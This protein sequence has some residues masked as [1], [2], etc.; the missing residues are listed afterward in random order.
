M[1][2]LTREDSE[3]VVGNKERVKIAAEK[4]AQFILRLHCDQNLTDSSINGVRT[5]YPPQNATNISEDSK[6]AAQIIHTEVINA[7]KLTNGG[8]H[9]DTVASIDPVVGMLVGSEEADKYKIPTVLVEMVYL[10]NPHDLA[11]IANFQNKE[12]LAK[13]LAQSTARIFDNIIS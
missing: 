6:K 9:D 2:I 11:W 12:L 13:T 1:V 4:G 5:F 8:I 10:S 7:T 3:K